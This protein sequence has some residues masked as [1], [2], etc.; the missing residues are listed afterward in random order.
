[1]RQIIAK[2]VSNP[3]KLFLVDS[4]GAFMT[5]FFLAVVLPT[6]EEYIGMPRRILVPLSAVA[7][8]FGLN[9]IF[10]YFFIGQN[11]KPFLKSICIANLVYCCLTTGLLIF[12]YASLTALGLMYF[13][14]E[15]ALICVLI[16]IERKALKYQVV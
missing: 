16:I 9:S 8:A 11:W 2:L 13:L 15:N 6:F 7:L 12:F 10:C 14:L 1:M 3:K 5:A 4:V